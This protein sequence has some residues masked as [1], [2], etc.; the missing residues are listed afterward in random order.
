MAINALDDNPD[1]LYKSMPVN[2]TVEAMA[3]ILGR[4]GSSTP[5]VYPH[6]PLG[7]AVGTS[8][9]DKLSN[10]NIYSNQL[11]SIIQERNL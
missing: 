7:S 8:L 11:T 10:L 4:E 2:G 9:T 6:T 3:S 5:W 1:P